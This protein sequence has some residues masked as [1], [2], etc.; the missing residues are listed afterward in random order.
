MNARETILNHY[1]EALLT[2]KTSRVLRSVKLNKIDTRDISDTKLP[3]A[4]VFSGKEVRGDFK[5]GVEWWEWD[6]VIQV[7]AQNEDMEELLDQVNAAIYQRY[8]DEE[9]VEILYRKS[10]ELYVTDSDGQQ[11]GWVLVYHN[12]Y[13]TNKG[14]T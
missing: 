11:Q 3:A 10:A 5:Y 2:L 1:E 6:I 14:T 12:T 9:F 7:W 8:V 13:E 4:W